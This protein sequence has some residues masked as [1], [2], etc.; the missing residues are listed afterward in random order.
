M[1]H[2]LTNRAN[3]KE[4]KKMNS[5]V[6]QGKISPKEFAQEYAKS[7]VEGQINQIKVASEISYK[8]TG[9]G[10]E[11]TNKLIESYTKDNSIDLS[12]ALKSSNDNDYFNAYETLGKSLREQYLREH[13]KIIF[14]KAKSKD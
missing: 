7:E 13:P 11:T 5:D 10:S 8:Y 6:E 1:T 14:K 3:L 4:L 2:E 12:K 9:K